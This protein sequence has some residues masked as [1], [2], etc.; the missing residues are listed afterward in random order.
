MLRGKNK[1]ILI[2]A[3]VLVMISVAFVIIALNI[4]NI[5]VLQKQ[6]IPTKVTIGNK[7]GIDANPETLSFGNVTFES[8]GSRNL[9]IGNSFD[10]PVKYGFDVEGNISEYLVFPDEVYL[11]VGEIKTLSFSTIF[12]TNEPKGHYNGRF[13]VKVRKWIK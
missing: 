12:I 5:T 13:I 10:F 11:E 8:Y 7:R 2:L 3:L 1:L 6:I 9:S 4:E